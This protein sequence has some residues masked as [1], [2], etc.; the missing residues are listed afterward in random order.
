MALAKETKTQLHNWDERQQLFH[1][2]GSPLPTEQ[3]IEYGS[4]IWDDGL[5]ASAFKYSRA[6]SSRISADTSLLDFFRDEV[7]K[8][9]TNLPAAQAKEKRDILL[10]ITE[11]W[12]SYVG[13]PVSRQSLKFFWLEECIEGENPFVAGTYSKILARVAQPVLEKAEVKFETK[14]TTIRCKGSEVEGERPG[15]TVE[16]GVRQDFDEVVVT[17][18]LGWLK[19]NKDAFE[20]RLDPEIEKAVDA[21]GY[22]CLDKVNIYNNTA[23]A[24]PMH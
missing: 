24:I 14:V 16:G 1:P 6:H 11:F 15:I 5:I 3:A 20:P 7:Q 9:F 13:S 8:L 12:G 23:Q 19:R 17:T 2:D 22:G 10:H 21:L 18:P 4:L